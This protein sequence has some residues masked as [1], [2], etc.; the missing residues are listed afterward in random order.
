MHVVKETR[1]ETYRRLANLA[2]EIGVSKEEVFGLLEVPDKEGDDG[3]A[4]VGNKVTDDVKLMVKVCCNIRGKRRKVL[5]VADVS[6]GES[7]DGRT[8]DSH[9]AIQ[10]KACFPRL[11]RAA[12]LCV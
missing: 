8:C 3:G 10:R 9:G 11:G 12:D 6:L 1:N 5:V 4:N 7:I 2:G